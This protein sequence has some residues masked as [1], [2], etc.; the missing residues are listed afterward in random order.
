MSNVIYRKA[1][2]DDAY[3]IEYVAAHSWKESYWDYMPHDYLETRVATVENKIERA[4]NLLETTN[5]Y[6]VA[7]IDNKVI[8]ILHYKE[9]Q[10]EKYRDYGYLESI[11]VL[12]KYQGQGIGKELFKIAINGLKEL[13]YNK[14][15]L[16]CLQGNKTINFYKKYSG[17]IIETIDFPIRDFVVKA[18]IVL[19]EDI[20]SIF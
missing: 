18:D 11:Y 16:E 6:Y 4:R 7:E 20:N 2:I 12:E 14:M 17:K 5:T 15:Y 8:G 9:S 1:T 19:F 10:N 3:G 13:G